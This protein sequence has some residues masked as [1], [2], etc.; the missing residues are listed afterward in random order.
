MLVD[1]ALDFYYINL[2]SILDIIWDIRDLFEAIFEGF[3][4]KRNIM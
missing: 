1:T 4:H 2:G 3:E